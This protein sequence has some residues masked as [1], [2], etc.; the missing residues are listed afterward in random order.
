MGGNWAPDHWEPPRPML[1]YGDTSL[2]LVIRKQE[3]STAGLSS[4]NN[5]MSQSPSL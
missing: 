5:Q 1:S 2:A 3:V 4:R